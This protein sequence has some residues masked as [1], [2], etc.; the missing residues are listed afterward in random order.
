[1]GKTQQQKRLG[2]VRAPKPNKSERLKSAFY[3]IIVGGII[4]AIAY[5]IIN[6]YY[7]MKYK[8]GLFDFPYVFGDGY[9]SALN[10]YKNIREHKT[11]LLVH[12]PRKVGK[13]RGLIEY[14]RYQIYN[15]KLAIVIDFSHVKNFTT[16]ADIVSLIADA[17]VSSFTFLNEESINLELLDEI[18]REIKAP[19]SLTSVKDVFGKSYDLKYIKEPSLRNAAAVIIQS[20]D[21][22][23]K[24]KKRPSMTFL[25]VL[26]KFGDVLFP[27]VELIQPNIMS[28]HK[29]GELFTINEMPVLGELFN[30]YSSKSHKVGIVMEVSNQT[31][32]LPYFKEKSKYELCYVGP[33]PLSAIQEVLVW[34]KSVLTLSQT[35]EFYDIYKGYLAPYEELARMLEHGIRYTAAEGII[36]KRADNKIYKVALQGRPDLSKRRRAFLVE[37]AGKDLPASNAAQFPELFNEDIICYTTPTTVGF[38]SAVY[39]Q[40]VTEFENKRWSKKI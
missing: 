35:E 28:A 39:R 11:Y 31:A 23:T 40:S 18:L 7:A 14:S 27:I 19:S 20:I 2:S 25:S 4:S 5:K 37:L 12:G 32:L 17:V 30:A 34:E 22:N 9:M 16:K 38:G 8:T 36:R 29:S 10:N 24:A 6:Y 21:G 3:L 1:M 13:T 26:D 33:V 15:G